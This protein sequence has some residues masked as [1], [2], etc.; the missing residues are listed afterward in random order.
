LRPELRKNK[1]I[2]LSGTNWSISMPEEPIRFANGAAYDRMM[3]VWTRF[4]GDIFLD[5]LALPQ[6]LGWADVGCG[7][8]AFTQLVVDR[9]RPEEVQGIDPSESQLAFARQRPAAKTAEFRPG[10]AMALPFQDSRFD[11]A[12]MALVLFFVPEPEKGVAEMMRVVRPGGT[13][14]AYVWDIPNGGFP[15]DPIIAALRAMGK[16]PVLPPRVDISTLDALE[17][18]WK[19]CG[20]EAVEA[21]PIAVERTFAD[22]EDYWLTTLGAGSLGDRIA[23]MPETEREQLK[24]GARARLP[25]E[26]DG[27]IIQKV[28][29]NAAKGRVPG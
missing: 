21:R 2:E 7:T 6:G 26:A 3:G 17:A 19:R 29:A 23:A 9:C 27:R 16:N 22:F 12:V 20:L 28:W 11:V 15:I 5:W 24:E 25:A 10:D 18:L 13:V 14:A 1:K 4:V 8:G